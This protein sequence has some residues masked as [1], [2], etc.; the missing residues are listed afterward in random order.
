MSFFLAIERASPVN[1]PKQ[2]LELT[3]TSKFFDAVVD[4]G[5]HIQLSVY[6]PPDLAR[7]T[8]K[9]ATSHEFK[10]T[11]VGGSFGPSWSTHWF[12][13]KLTVPSDLLKKERLEFH[14]DA[15]NEGLVWNEDGVPLQGLTGGGERVEW[16]LPDE[17][18]DGKE[19][20]FYIE[21][22]CNGMFGNAPG[23]DS[24]Q[25]PN[26]NKYFQLHCAKIV[27]VNLEARALFIDFWIIG[28]TTIWP[29][30]LDIRY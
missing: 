8:F 1:T 22:A 15:N 26:P 21:M 6:S 16:I 20:T 19:H 25:P 9:D 11:H 24:I 28:G 3:Y 13:I 2:E 29:L 14:W 27:A 5:D 18:R 30:R 4:D 17:F 7:P 12:K 23:G 10:K